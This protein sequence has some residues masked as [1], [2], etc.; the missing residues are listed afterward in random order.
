MTR[1]VG[2]RSCAGAVWS[3]DRPH[4]HRHRQRQRHRGW[5]PLS[6]SAHTTTYTTSV[7]V[8]S[9]AGRGDRVG[10]RPG[11][12]PLP[13]AGDGRAQP[14][15]P[16]MFKPPEDRDYRRHCRHRDN[17]SS[18]PS[19]PGP[20]DLGSPS[21]LING[22]DVNKTSSAVANPGPS[23]LQRRN[24]SPLPPPLSL[25]VVVSSSCGL[26]PIMSLHVRSL[27]SIWRTVQC[28]C[29]LA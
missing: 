21:A 1:T 22:N 29:R 3:T 5:P 9:G 4:C 17:R 18:T 7:A 26:S 19:T 13:T 11:S 10:R 16:A 23:L 25:R 12:T 24:L 14:Q 2:G 8:A 6:S 28:C 20:C 15:R 27:M